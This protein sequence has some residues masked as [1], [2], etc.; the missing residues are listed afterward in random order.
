MY[1][2]ILDIPILPVK[3]DA[4]IV[5]YYKNLCN[6]NEITADNTLHFPRLLTYTHPNV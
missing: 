6:Y 5:K 3:S 1:I 2:E 4:V